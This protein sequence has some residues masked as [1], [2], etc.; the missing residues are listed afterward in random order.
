MDIGKVGGP[1]HFPPD[2]CGDQPPDV[3]KA[4]AG[5]ESALAKFSDGLADGAGDFFSGVGDATSDFFSGW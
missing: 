4:Q 5:L 3:Q 2:T 1:A